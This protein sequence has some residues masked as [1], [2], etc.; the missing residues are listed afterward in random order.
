MIKTLFH[1][2]KLKLRE[3]PQI[4]KKKKTIYKGKNQQI[5]SQYIY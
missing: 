5:L 4:T 2:M 1:K 3:I